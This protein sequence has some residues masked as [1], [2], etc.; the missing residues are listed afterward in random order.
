MTNPAGLG[1]KLVGN[2]EL[3]IVNDHLRYRIDEVEFPDGSRGSYTYIDDDYAAAA[4]VPLDKRRGELN[5]FLVRQ[6]RYPSQ[7]VGWEVPAGR[8]EAGE[9]QLEAA[10]RELREEGGLVAEFW[11]QLPRQ[12][13]N[14]GRGNSRS[15]LFVAAGLTVVRNQVEASEVITDQAW[16]PI[17]EVEEMMLDGKISAG[18]TMAS[19]ALARALIS[20]TPSHPITRFLALGLSSA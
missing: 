16:F 1:T 9:S 11:H 7:T 2:S 17:G 19:I 10:Q 8:P 20:R 6:E 14:V 13:E 4:T 3:V 5:V 18:H 15:D 12:L